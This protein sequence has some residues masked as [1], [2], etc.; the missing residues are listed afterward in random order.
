MPNRW[1]ARTFEVPWQPPIDAARAASKL[2]CAPCARRAPNSTTGRPWAAVTTPGR[3]LVGAARVAQRHLPAPPQRLGQDPQVRHF[4][5]AAEPGRHVQVDQR[6]GAGPSGRP[7]Y[8]ASPVFPVLDAQPG[9]DPDLALRGHG[10]AFQAKLAD[11]TRHAQ[12]QQ[13]LGFFRAQATERE[14]VAVE[15]LA[16]TFW[17]R[18]GQHRNPG[19]AE[20]LKVAVDRA[21]R[22]L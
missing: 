13:G 21:D 18:L 15:K 9:G 19:R 2:A 8:P 20:R 6:R 5:V 14:A 10:R 1:P 3:H 16:A 12:D 7:A 4:L 11:G 17:P 22:D